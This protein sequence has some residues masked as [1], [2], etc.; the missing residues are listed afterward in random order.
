M[1]TQ[2]PPRLIALLLGVTLLLA[3]CAKS[4][5]APLESSGIELFRPLI[6]EHMKNMD[7]IADE[8]IPGMKE[9]REQG[10]SLAG[11]DA[12][13]IRQGQ[14]YPLRLVILYTVSGHVEDFSPLYFLYECDESGTARQE[15]EIISGGWDYG[16]FSQSARLYRFKKDGS[17]RFAATELR[18]W[19]ES[20][21]GFSLLELDPKT[22][23]TTGV[24]LNESLPEAF[25][26]T[27]Y[28]GF[29]SA[30][31]AAEALFGEELAPYL[32][33][34][35]IELEPLRVEGARHIQPGA[36]WASLSFEELP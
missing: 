15:P 7:A 22:L 23:E 12:L 29:P 28:E 13:L 3:A 33:A 2:K 21:D 31:A 34:Q 16:Q 18:F 5:A 9:M 20:G 36:S 1:R 17:V 24:L 14:G 30:Y 6:E 27:E 19:R 26:G 8:R 35:G 25:Y 11:I 4:H 32:A 10:L